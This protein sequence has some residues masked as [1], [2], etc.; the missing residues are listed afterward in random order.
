MLRKREWFESR[1][2]CIYI[3]CNRAALRVA[4]HLPLRK[5]RHFVVRARDVHACSEIPIKRSA[6]DAPPVKWY[7][8]AVALHDRGYRERALAA[9]RHH[10]RIRVIKYSTDISD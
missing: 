1:K 10:L 7:R 5:R 3:L 6:R 8:R 2:S 4:A 9:A